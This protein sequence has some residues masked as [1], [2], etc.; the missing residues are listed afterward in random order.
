[1]SI[2]RIAYLMLFVLLLFILIAVVSGM[3]FP[4]DIPVNLWINGIQSSFLDST[5]QLIS[6]P[7]AFPYCIIFSLLSG[8]I[9]WLF[10]KK[11]ESLFIIVVPYI[12]VCISYTLKFLIDRPRPLDDL[13]ENSFPSGHTIYTSILMGLIIYFL[14]LAVKNSTLCKMLQIAA[15]LLIALMGFSRL[16]LQQHWLSDIISSLIIGILVLVPAIILY[17]YVMKREIKCLNFLKSKP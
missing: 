11:I 4:G 8:L 10:K 3:S 14:P 2:Y 9:F 7:G 6:Y 16:Y 12:G 17:K 15:G 13:L 5:M 1:L